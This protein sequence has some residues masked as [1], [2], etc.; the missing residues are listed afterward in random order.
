MGNPPEVP[1][2][3]GP[4]I[5]SEFSGMDPAL[6]K[7]FIEELERAARVVAEETEGI[8][9]ELSAA[10]LPADRLAAAREVSGW[11]EDEIPKLRQ[12]LQTITSPV[13]LLHGGLTPFEE[14]ILLPPGEA[15][16]QGAELAKRFT[17]IDLKTFHLDP[18]AGQKMRD[19]IEELGRH[20]HDA[21]FTAAF[22]AAVGP[23]GLKP[24]ADQIN[25]FRGEDTMVPI[26]GTALAGAISG[27][28]SVPGFS[29][30]RKRIEQ[31]KG[32]ELVSIAP[33]LTSG[34]YPA[35]WLARV[36]VPMLD[37]DKG[38]AAGETLRSILT[39]LGNNPAAARLA[40]G[41][42]TGLSPRKLPGHADKPALA[43]GTFN[44]KTPFGN[45]P[46]SPQKW[47]H[48]PD[49][50]NYLK[51]L[52]AWVKENEGVPGKPLGTPGV[53]NAFGQMLAAAAGA[54]DE[55][56]GE[57]SKNA[58]FFA[59]TVMTTF[60]ELKPADGTRT[61]LSEIAGSYAPELTLGADMGDSDLTQPSAFVGSPERADLVKVPGLVGSFRISPEET[62]LF[63]KT[64]AGREEW[65]L[66]FEAGMGQLAERL[67][68]ETARLAKAQGDARVMSSLFIALGN[69]RGFELAAIQH[70]LN[71]DI[72]ADEAIFKAES[73]GIG[74]AMG[75]AGLLLPASLAS[76]ATWTVLSTGVSAVDA[77]GRAEHDDAIKEVRKLEDIQV[78]GR[79][80]WTADR[81][82]AL[83]FMPRV[84]PGQASN[85]AEALIADK[86]GRLLPF[87]EIVKKH[88]RAGL[89]ALDQWHV[90]NGLGTNDALALGRLSRDMADAFEARRDP[91]MRR[92]L[93][94]V[95]DPELE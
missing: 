13:A 36:A 49:L 23:D 45:L 85:D 86:D 21:D 8:R 53:A 83:G 69:V 84:G 67:L 82:M 80:H 76:A 70:E 15:Q 2:G 30:I 42:V 74:A 6:M 28:G 44:V 51:Q 48:L 66:P 72:D 52:N 62:F 64:F 39:A 12:R 17:A 81:L 87:N 31:A 40:L 58:A 54:Y 60:D 35:E 29:A 55:R 32:A 95:R 57:H 10:G 5:P 79:Q 37:L 11:L 77:Y 46:G 4:R 56:Q 93:G 3:S 78:L 24:L 20:R 1:P 16:R 26:L 68:P 90:D 59:F 61:H 25:R 88:G 43:L 73:I 94:Y 71:P 65:R 92:A 18:N 27:G 47:R 63:M 7:R 9:R 50:A 38:P 41:A 33:L 14:T 22:F 89:K 19:V 34:T 91:G 75:L